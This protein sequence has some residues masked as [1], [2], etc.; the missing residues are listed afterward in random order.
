MDEFLQ[1]DHVR[2]VAYALQILLADAFDEEEVRISFNEMISQWADSPD[3]AQTIW[4][5]WKAVMAEE[6]PDLAQYLVREWANK[7]AA[8]PERAVLMIRQWYDR[9]QPLWDQLAQ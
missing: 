9:L 1:H 2:N 5:D 8:D 4:T 3:Y 6:D 7:G